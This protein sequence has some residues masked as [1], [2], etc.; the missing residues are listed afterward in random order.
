LFRPDNVSLGYPEILELADLSGLPAT[1]IAP[2]RPERLVVHEVLIRVMADISFP[3]GEVYADLGLNFRRI[4]ATL[5]R[6][7]VAH[8]LDAVT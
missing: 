5:L 2:F 3:V 6:E 4:V 1:Q 8:R 7:G